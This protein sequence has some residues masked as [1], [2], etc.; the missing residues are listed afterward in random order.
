MFTK[1]IKINNMFYLISE[2]CPDYMKAFHW[3]H[4][5]LD[6]KMAHLYFITKSTGLV[7]RL[8]YINSRVT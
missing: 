4:K 6:S 3:K 5:K 7:Q 8:K 1:S 2:A